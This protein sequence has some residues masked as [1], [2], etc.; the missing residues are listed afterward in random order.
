MPVEDF[1]RL[2]TE[3]Y[4]DGVVTA[5]IRPAAI[6]PEE[7]ARLVLVELAMRDVHSGG[8]WHATPVLW[9][10]FDR[11]TEPDQPLDESRVLG[12]LQ[13]AYGTP[14]RYDITIYRATVTNLGQEQG[15]TVESL[16]D[17]A[18]GYGGLSLT[19]CPR[20]DLQP[21]PAPFKG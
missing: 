17:E 1:E 8:H 12:S 7:A 9:R 19:D 5:V 15:W 21:P 10:R 14:T 18:L 4:D 11:P 6:V 13:V 3:A 2:M 20:A 16:V